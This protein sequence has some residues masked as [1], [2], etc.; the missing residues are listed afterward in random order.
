RILTGAELMLQVRSVTHNDASKFFARECETQS[1]A[2]SPKCRA[3]ARF[4]FDRHNVDNPTGTMKRR[5]L[6]SWDAE[7]QRQAYGKR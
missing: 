6:L 5:V 4:V 3:S 1:A 7:L 2:L